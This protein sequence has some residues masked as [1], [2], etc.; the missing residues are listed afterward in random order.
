MQEFL[1]RRSKKAGLAPGSLIHIGEK[2]IDK[3]KV[4]IIN[5]NEDSFEEKEIKNIEECKPCKESTINTW[6]NIEG[7]HDIEILEKV[8]AY[9]NIHPLAMED[10][11]NTDQRP[12]YD[13][14]INNLYIVLKMLS[15]NPKNNEIVVEQ[16]SI[17]LGSNF[18]ISFQEGI[19]GDVFNPVRERL[20]SS[21][22]KIRKEGMDY[23]AYSL[24]DIIIDNYFLILEKI[25]D[26]LETLQSTLVK[27]TES[28]LLTEIYAL[29]KEIVFLRKSVWPLREVISNLERLDSKL[30]NSTT[31]IY[32]RDIYDHAI[33][34]IDTIE[35]FRDIIGGLLEIYLT[36]LTNKT[37]T[38]MKV[39]TVIATIFMPPTFIV[40]VYGMNFKYMPELE[41]KWSYPLVL[42]FN[43]LIVILMLIYF[44]KKRWL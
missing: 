31:K 15:F 2:L 33:Q 21:K 1:K 35:S 10:I 38:V 36:Q 27:H 37:N 41:Y 29:K 42:L 40:G 11:L 34:I 4:S 20:R 23:L 9:F 13:D 17:I 7:I 14:F 19:K 5:Y 39:L 6:I 43:I 44:K 12:K 26:Q 3:P 16:V 8:G 22:G 32:L 25:G 28:K 30:I 24:L 18:L